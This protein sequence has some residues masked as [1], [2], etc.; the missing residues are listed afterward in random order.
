MDRWT[1][2]EGAAAPIAPR[3]VKPVMRAG[4]VGRG[5]VY[6]LVG[7]LTLFA[8]WRGGEAEDAQSALS[9]VR[10]MPA[11]SVLIGA[12]AL[13]LLAYALYRAVNG[14]LD[15]DR[16][17]SGAKGLFARGAMVVVALVHVGLAGVAA[18][19]ALHLTGGRGETGIDRYTAMLLAWPFGRW[20]VAGIGLAVLGAGLY[21]FWKGWSEDYRE[22]IVESPLTRRLAPVLRFGLIAHGAVIAL[23]GLFFLGAGWNYDASQAGGLGQAFD[24]IR[25]WTFGRVLLGIAAVGFVAFAVVCWV[26]AAY[27]IVPARVSRTDRRRLL[28]GEPAGKVVGG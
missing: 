24:A 1:A 9:E 28:S 18:A 20:L 23:V 19:V 6:A 14:W 10:D 7:V 4:Y 27:R 13:A 5:V 16:Y 25:G 3:W 22:Q 17:G 26:Y 2:N 21:Y 12:V 11:G 15:L 8:A